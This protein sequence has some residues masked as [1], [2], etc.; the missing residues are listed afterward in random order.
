MEF[1]AFPP[2]SKEVAIRSFVTI[3]SVRPLAP[4]RKDDLATEVSNYVKIPLFS[5]YN[6]KTG[7]AASLAKATSEQDGPPA[8]TPSRPSMGRG[9]HWILAGL[10]VASLIVVFATRKRS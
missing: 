6:P 2:N 9:G 7:R 10:G 3:T 1:R 5:A 4:R 8:A